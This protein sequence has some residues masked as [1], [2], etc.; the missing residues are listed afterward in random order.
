VRKQATLRWS[1][2]ARPEAEGFDNLTRMVREGLA[3]TLQQPGFRGFYLL[4]D[5]E[6]D[7]LMTISLWETKEDLQASVARAAGQTTLASAVTGLRVDTYE[8]TLSA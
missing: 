8:V 5:P 7:K 3:G 2:L 1:A 4:R 6:S